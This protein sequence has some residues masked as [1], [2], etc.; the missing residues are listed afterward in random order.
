MIWTTNPLTVPRRLTVPLRRLTVPLL[1]LSAF[2]AI[3]LVVPDYFWRMHRQETAFKELL[4]DLDLEREIRAQ[5][6]MSEVVRRKDL[7]IFDLRTRVLES[8]LDAVIAPRNPNMTMKPGQVAHTERG[9][10]VLLIGWASRE[11]DAYITSRH[12]GTSIHVK[13][14]PNMRWPKEVVGKLL[15]IE[16]QLCRTYIKT[17]VVNHG[18]RGE[19]INALLPLP[20]GHMYY[21]K[22]VVWSVYGDRESWDLPGLE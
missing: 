19:H 14:V 4:E 7:R 13:V 5:D 12:Q 3:I 22:D 2:V 16:G 9:Q 18:R 8:D 15:V 10:R 17:N 20:V 11:L 1:K 6:R 21:V